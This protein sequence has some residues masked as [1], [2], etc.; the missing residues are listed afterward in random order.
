MNGQAH[1]STLGPW[2][3]KGA[4]RAKYNVTRADFQSNPV[5][6]HESAG[7]SMALRRVTERPGYHAISTTEEIG[8]WQERLP[9]RFSPIRANGQVK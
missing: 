7:P 5:T 2:F 9:T 8:D 3:K 4:S 6:V 1:R